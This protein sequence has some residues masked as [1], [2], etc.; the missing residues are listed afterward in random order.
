[1]RRRIREDPIKT[2]TK[3][4]ETKTQSEEKYPENNTQ[5]TAITKKKMER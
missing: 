2:Q 3:I 5:E 4:S 1:M